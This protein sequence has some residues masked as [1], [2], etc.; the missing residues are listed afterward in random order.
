[1]LTTQ[2]H[3][4]RGLQ[5]TLGDDVAAAHLQGV[6]HTL[7]Q[8][9]RKRSHPRLHTRCVLDV[10]ARKTALAAVVG[11]ATD[12]RLCSNPHEQSPSRLVRVQIRQTHRLRHLRV[13]RHRAAGVAVARRDL[14]RRRVLGLRSSVA[15]VLPTLRGAVAAATRLLHC[16]IRLH[17]RRVVC[18]SAVASSVDWRAGSVVDS[19]LC[20]RRAVPTAWRRRLPVAASVAASLRRGGWSV[21]RRLSRRRVGGPDWVLLGTS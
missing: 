9:V 17:W 19:G 21:G 16:A 7:V 5:L 1:M 8:R 18:V 13:A 4:F 10:E 6:V 20:S 3:L 15:L 12:V 2:T 14:L 11:E